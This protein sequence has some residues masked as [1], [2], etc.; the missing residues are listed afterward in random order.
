MNQVEKSINRKL[1]EQKG[2]VMSV[3]R[4]RVL[5]PFMREMMLIIIPQHV[6]TRSIPDYKGKGDPIQHIQ[7]HESS[8]L[9]RT[10]DNNHFAFLLLVILTENN[11]H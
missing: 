7:K 6:T 2:R 9:G 5:H 8:I 3:L 1:K 11:S 4:D 10:S